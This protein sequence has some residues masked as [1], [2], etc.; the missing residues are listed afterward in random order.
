MPT[1]LLVWFCGLHLQGVESKLN[2]VFYWQRPQAV[3]ETRS[4]QKIQDLLNNDKI[5]SEGNIF[6]VHADK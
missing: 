5:P 6:G 4:M 1:F 2:D 3:V